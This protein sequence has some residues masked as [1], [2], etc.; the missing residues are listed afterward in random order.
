MSY[1]KREN[2]D[3]SLFDNILE[4]ADSEYYLS[5][6]FAEHLG[7]LLNG[8]FDN[9][10][11]R[12]I[13][14]ILVV[15]NLIDKHQKDGNLIDLSSLIFELGE[16]DEFVV[17]EPVSPDRELVEDLL[18]ERGCTYAEINAVLIALET[19]K[20]ARIIKEM[21]RIEHL[22]DVLTNPTEYFS[23]DDIEKHQTDESETLRT[24][25]TAL[26]AVIN[27]P[28]IASIVY[29]YVQT[30]S[31]KLKNRIQ[32]QALKSECSINE[33]FFGLLDMLKP[34]SKELDE[35]LDKVIKLLK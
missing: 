15:I 9:V 13:T 11:K 10:E 30:S 4:R 3:E 28:Q 2:G 12:S 32:Q 31:S 20:C 34:G 33:H 24:V 25:T 7:D 5:S 1:E 26:V 14:G 17:D 29:N 35:I 8:N 22:Q 6:T 19:E 21:C 18:L 27:D 16:Y 23:Q